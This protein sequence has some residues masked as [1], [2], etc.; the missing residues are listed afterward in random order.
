VR[1]AFEVLRHPS[2]SFDIANPEQR[3]SSPRVILL[4]GLPGSGKTT[5]AR[6]LAA[7]LGAVRL[8]PDEWLA[9]LGFDLFD[10]AARDRVERRLWI[11]AEEL[12]AIGVTAVLENGFWTRAE[13]D[14]LRRRARELGT[15]IELRY[16][17]VPRDERRRRIVQRNNE[18]GATVLDPDVLTAYD[19]L[20]E[21]PTP[22]ESA[23]F[24]P[25][26]AGAG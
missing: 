23:L 10:L 26:A 18:P 6:R 3:L 16:L 8:S 1:I 13:R 25:R 5:E 4:C 24:D 19:E 11:H 2:T 21:A 20:F 7:E 15:P 12:L 14:T 22:A 17:D 9:A